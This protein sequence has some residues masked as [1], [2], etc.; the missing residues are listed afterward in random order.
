MVVVLDDIIADFNQCHQIQIEDT[1]YSKMDI[2]D[3]YIILR[4][5]CGFHLRVIHPS[6]TKIMCRQGLGIYRCTKAN[7]KK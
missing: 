6:C 3:T 7:E 4:T 5:N 2:R 1:I